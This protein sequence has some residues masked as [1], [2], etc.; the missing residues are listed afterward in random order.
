[1]W[2]AFHVRMRKSAQKHALAVLRLQLGLGQKELAELVEC[3]RPTIQ[4]IELGR[5][6]LSDKLAD[7]IS[8]ET[9]VSIAWLKKNDLRKPPLDYQDE[10]YGK[11]V[12]E[13]IQANRAMRDEHTSDAI[14]RLALVIQTSRIAGLFLSAYKRGEFSLCSYKLAKALDDLEARFGKVKLDIL[15][16]GSI[17]ITSHQKFDLQRI[18]DLFDETLSRH[19]RSV[20]ESK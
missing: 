3:S 1:M 16:K 8:R 5:L 10:P 2:Y 13:R 19:S 15:S 18:A 4:S 20:G 14:A 9:G 17:K 11:E 7:R 6:P 12:F